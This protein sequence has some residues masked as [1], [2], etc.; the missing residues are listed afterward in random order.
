MTSFVRY[1]YIRSLVVSDESHVISIL[2]LTNKMATVIEEE[3]PQVSLLS[4]VNIPFSVHKIV[5][6]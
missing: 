6:T 1:M 2:A 4:C 5:R 3:K